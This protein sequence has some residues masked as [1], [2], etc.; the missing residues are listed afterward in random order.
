MVLR[1]QDLWRAHPIF[2]WGFTDALPG[3]REAAVAFTVYVAGEWA[4][5]NLVA[6]EAH[7]TSH[8][9]G[10]GHGHAGHDGHAAAAAVH[11][12]KPAAQHH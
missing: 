11:G 12:A 3:F 4:Y 5:K 7:G 10:L 2:K 1:G 6:D 9:H 8:G